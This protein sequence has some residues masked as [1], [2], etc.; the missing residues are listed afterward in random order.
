MAIRRSI[1]FDESVDNEL[2]Q[3]ID[4]IEFRNRSHAVQSIIKTWLLCRREKESGE[5]TNIFDV[6]PVAKSRPKK[7]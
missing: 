7:K 5:Q 6:R 2:N 3:Y 1:L 4:G